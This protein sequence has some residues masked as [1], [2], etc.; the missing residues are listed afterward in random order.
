[1]NSK[2][3]A[4][5]FAHLPTLKQQAFNLLDVLRLV[6]I[7]TSIPT[8]ARWLSIFARALGYKD[9]G[10][11]LH[12]AN[13]YTHNSNTKI[14]VPENLSSIADSI[15]T[16]LGDA[17]V[18]INDLIDA[19]ISI[20]TNEEKISNDVSPE[21]TLIPPTTYILEFGPKY[22][23]E[24][25]LLEYMWAYARKQ[26]VD[27]LVKQYAF[28]MKQKRAGLSKSDMKAQYLD[29]YPSSGVKVKDL[30]DSLVQ[31]GYVDIKDEKVSISERGRNFIRGY[32]TDEFGEEWS[33]WWVKFTKLYSEIPFKVISNKWDHYIKLYSLGLNPKEAVENQYWSSFEKRIAEAFSNQAKKQF[34]T[35]EFPQHQTQRYFLFTPLL[36]LN[37]HNVG[38]KLND[39][40]LTF[41]G[42]DWA[43]PTESINVARFVPNK[44]YVSGYCGDKALSRGWLQLIPEDIA[45]FK[46]TYI[47][48]SK[49]NNFKRTEHTVTYNLFDSPNSDNWLF[50]PRV[51]NEHVTNEYAFS[52]LNTLTDGKKLSEDEM[53]NLDRVKAGI[54]Y[55]D[56]NADRV[57]I[58]EQKNLTASNPYSISML[59]DF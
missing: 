3:L 44:H 40:E 29:V 39:I 26:T 2:T 45:E 34:N 1:M 37:N 47:W 55:L 28:H 50:G 13:A 16:S 43:N 20:G 6:D 53:R 46:V 15:Y 18:Q 10:T 59:Y 41:I 49:K 52:S 54:H 25:P 48:T 12:T 36:F 57:L 11:L 32:L 42:P 4:F 22:A 17:N 56:I 38:L 58:D 31:G 9:W 7:T 24:Q 23:Y 35:A 27:D 8:K 33:D 21:F 19:I 14:F 30:L 51:S 5:S